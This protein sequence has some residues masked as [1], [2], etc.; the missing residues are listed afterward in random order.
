MST[1]IWTIG[2]STRPI[3][4]F[5]AA[6][7]AHG[8]RLVADVRLHPGSRRYPQF[9]REALRDSLGKAGLRYAH[10]PELGGRRTP[11]PDSQNT[12]WRNEAFRGYADH[13]ETPGFRDAIASFLQAADERDLLF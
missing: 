7:A 6:L 3:D 11:R 1:T 10:F 12:A 4:D 8:V 13:M 5:L 2:H 9:N